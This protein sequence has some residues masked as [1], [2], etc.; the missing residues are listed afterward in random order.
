MPNTSVMSPAPTAWTGLRPTTSMKKGLKN[1]APETP[2]PMATVENRMETGNTHHR[3]R[4]ESIG[5]SSWSRPAGDP[6]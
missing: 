6:K 2:D 1:R 5:T 4:K 3:V